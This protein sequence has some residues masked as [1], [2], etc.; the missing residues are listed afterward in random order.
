MG[1]SHL[2]TGYRDMN[3]QIYLEPR[4]KCGDQI[5]TNIMNTLDRAAPRALTGIRRL[6]RVAHLPRPHA[7]ADFWVWNYF[8]HLREDADLAAHAAGGSLPPDSLS[9]V[10][11]AEKL[12]ELCK[13]DPKLR[14]AKIEELQEILHEL[15]KAFARF[16]A[17]QAKFPS[18][19]HRL[20]N[21]RPIGD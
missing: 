14:K 5:I 16:D 15:D 12:P 2:R 7:E 4:F 6:W 3:S 8:V 10:R 1:F 18:L 9:Y 11:N 13:S 20:W 21:R 19:R 17:G